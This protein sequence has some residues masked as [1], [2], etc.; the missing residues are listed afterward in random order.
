LKN[1][2]AFDLEWSTDDYGNKKIYAAAFVD[3]LGISKVLHISDFN[4]NSEADFLQ[5]IDN[6]ISK[7]PLSIGWYTSGIEAVG[8]D[9]D[10]AVFDDR[11]FKNNID[12]KIIFSNNNIPSIKGKEHIDLYQVFQKE[13]VKNSIF[14]NKYKSLKLGD[15]SKALLEKGKHDGITGA[16]VYTKSIEEQ[17]KYVLKDAELVLELSKIN[18]GQVLDLM[19]A[20]SEL[21][22]LDFVQVCHTNI[23]AWWAK[24][25]DDV[26]CRAIYHN[27]GHKKYDYEGRFVIEPKKGLYYDLKVVDVVS[28][29]PSMAILHNISFDTVN[30]GC[31]KDSEDARVAAEVIDK[32]YWIC[33]EKEG[34]FPTKL[35]EF[36]AERIRQKQ[37]GNNIKQQGL[38]ILINGGYGLFGN[39]GFKYSD[40]R[41]AELI[42]AYGRY[43]LST[44]Q[45]ISKSLGFEVVAGDTDSLF[46]HGNGDISKFIA[47]CKEKLDVDVEHDKIFK[48]AVIIKKKHYFGVTD[49]GEIIIKGMEGTKNDRP[50]WINN[51][52]NQ[53]V[54]DFA[55]NINPLVNLRKS[56]ADLEAEKV[57]MDLLKISVK[58]SKDPK[59]YAVNNPQKKIGLLLNAKAG[60]VIEYYKSNNADGISINPKDISIAKYKE[61]LLSSVND[62]LEIWGC[63]L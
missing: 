42:T 37:L 56:I 28:L 46:L 25:F 38:K 51:V 23:S 32:V 53:F 47:E 1:Y 26:G 34:S 50:A 54:K 18:N 49:E 27:N 22:G 48:K 33:K 6:E 21:T 43:T 31:C 3:N 13:M 44:M 10:L 45:E 39:E 35:K 8:N 17:K 41:V 63:R 11:C 52:F 40:V 30:C 14:K 61:M 60:D 2:V 15:V 36:K 4:Y 58:L 24:V 9:S 59:Q 20:I 5:A 55:N 7:Y 62:A 16:N 57:S 29:Y 19:N 12:S